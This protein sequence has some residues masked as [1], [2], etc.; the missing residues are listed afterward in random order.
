L[1]TAIASGCHERAYVPVGASRIFPD[2]SRRLGRQTSGTVSI[3]GCVFED[4][5]RED[6]PSRLKTDRTMPGKLIEEVPAPAA[7]D[8]LAR[9]APK[10]RGTTAR[11]GT[12]TQG[13]DFETASS[14]YRMAA[15]ISP[16]FPVFGGYRTISG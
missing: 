9:A 5:G 10:I 14:G 16:I 12:H 8:G 4:Q 11:Y 1:Y 3:G 6:C 13:A 7:P 2:F 15:V